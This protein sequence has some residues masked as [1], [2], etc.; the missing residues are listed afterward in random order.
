[1][2][3]GIA[4]TGAGSYIGLRL[5]ERLAA[6]RERPIV[7]IASPRSMRPEH[8]PPWIRWV[9]MDLAAQ[10]PALGE[11]LQSTGVLLHLAWARTGGDEQALLARNTAMIRQLTAALPDPGAFWF[12]SSVSASSQ[13]RSSYGRIKFAMEQLVRNLGGSLLSVGLVVERDPPAGPY[14]MLRSLVQKLPF[15]FRTTLGSVP[16]YPIRM[17]DFL[18]AMTRLLDAPPPPGAYRVFTDPLPFNAFM[19]HLEAGFTRG[20]MP[21]PLPLPLLLA[22]ARAWQR[23][24]LPPR[25][26]VDQILTLF[27]K[28]AAHLAKHRPLPGATFEAC[29]GTEFFR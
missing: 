9:Q 2:T 10:T 8:L 24:G 18:P 27:Y 17:D 19:R 7:A 16:V 28:D 29:S 12:L 26:P 3:E 22:G 15:A 11:I 6:G 23:T 4:L 25:K 5:L 1:M 20:R 14:K 21:L 13:A